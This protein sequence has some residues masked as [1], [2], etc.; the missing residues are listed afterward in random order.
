MNPAKIY[1][2]SWV[3]NL[4]LSHI[5]LIIGTSIGAVENNK[6]A[7][8]RLSVLSEAKKSARLANPTVARAICIVGCFARRTS[9]DIL[10]LRIFSTTRASARLVA[11]LQKSISGIEMLLCDILTKTLIRAANR[12]DKSTRPHALVGLLEL[13]RYESLLIV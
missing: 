11:Y 8:D 13:F 9:L 1:G 6:V 12:H 2:Q 4:T 3:C 10:C 5:L 7:L